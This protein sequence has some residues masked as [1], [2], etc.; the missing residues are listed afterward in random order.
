MIYCGS[1]SYFGK[2]SISD[3]VSVSV[4]V[5]APVPV[6]DT[7]LFTTFFVQNLAFSML[8]ADFFPKK[9]ADKF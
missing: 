1:G 2:V 7:V 5:P 6:P 3:P 8:E 9:S 4:P